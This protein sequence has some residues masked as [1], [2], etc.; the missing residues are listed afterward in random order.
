MQKKSSW[1]YHLRFAAYA[2]S[3]LGKPMSQAFRRLQYLALILLCSAATLAL[4]DIAGERL[5]P[6]TNATR[7]WLAMAVD[8]YSNWLLTLTPATILMAF[9]A[10]IRPRRRIVRVVWLGIGLLCTSIIGTIFKDYLLYGSDITWMIVKWRKVA[11]ESCG[12]ALPTALLITLYE[13]HLRSLD[14]AEAALRVQADR[15]MKAAQLN[16]ARLRLLHAQI[17]PHFIFNS[18]AHVRRLYQ[19]D[20]L[21]GRQMLTAVIH[22]FA[23]A[24]PS[25]R[26]ETCSLEQEAALIT[27]YLD[28]HRLRMGSRLAYDVAFPTNLLP[29]RIPSMVLLTLVENAIKHGLSP[30]PEGGYVRIS[31]S[32][33]RELLELNVADSG[34]G[35]TEC[36]GCGIGLANIRTRLN[37][38]Y[39]TSAALKLSTNQPR[40]ITATI[41]LPM[42]LLVA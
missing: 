35:V 11:A 12:I 38:L 42:R 4:Y 23:S 6:A 41:R 18:L 2:D 17:E 22:Y 3:A 20:P 30:L 40:G 34:R 28:I 15:I 24:F 8:D 16:K 36:S 21:K 29:L 13:V 31:A 26:Q 1:R 5:E 37:S 25:L 9:I 10:G 27:A 32:Q 33:T 39:G 19:V 14:A 7:G